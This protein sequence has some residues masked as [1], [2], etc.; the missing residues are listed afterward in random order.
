MIKRL[1]SQDDIALSQNIENYEHDM[2]TVISNSKQNLQTLSDRQSLSQETIPEVPSI[3][4]ENANEEKET[5]SLVKVK[6][7]EDYVR[8]TIQSGL[9]N[10]QYEVC[11]IN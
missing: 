10:K 2:K 5:T 11:M 9:L 7:F 1:L 6:D 4:I 3:T 8:E